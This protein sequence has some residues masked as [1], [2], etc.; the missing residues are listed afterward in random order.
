M[1]RLWKPSVAL[2]GILGLVWMCYQQGI[3]G[4]FL[5]DDFHN[6]ETMGLYG[7]IHDWNTLYTFI[8]TG[9]SG[10]SGRPISLLSFLLDDNTWPS[11]AAWFKVTNVWIHLLCALVLCWNNILILRLIGLKENNTQWMAVFAAGAWALHPF[12]VSTT[13]YVV[14]R[15]AQLSTLF[16]LLGMLGYLFG[17][18]FVS[19]KPRKAYLWM[20]FSVL[21]GTVLAVLSKEN[22]ALLPL[23]L[24]VLEFCLSPKM[25]VPKPHIVWRLIFLITPSLVIIGYLCSLVDFSAHPW[26]GRNFNQP[27]RLMSESRILVGYLRDLVFPSIEGKGLFQD[28]F[29]VSKSLL[30]PQ[31]T[32]PSV[33]LI[34]FLVLFS[35]L[36][37]N[38]YPVLC[39]GLLFFFC[40]HLIESTLVGLELYFEHRNYLP[41]C[42]LFL[43][44]SVGINELTKYGY[45]KISFVIGVA[46]IIFLS[47]MTWKRSELW[48]NTEK[49]QL[50]WAVSS[51]ASARAQNAL[52]SY[53]LR[54]GRYKEANKVLEN[55]MNKMPDS[56]FLN[57]AWLLQKTYLLQA[58]PED[59][60]VTTKRL[61]GQEF[62]AQSIVALRTLVD[63]SNLSKSP[64]FY[65]DETLKLINA[66]EDNHKYAEIPDVSRLL[67][68]LKGKIYLRQ[69]KFL[70]ACDEYKRAISLYNS[71]DSGLMMVAENTSAHNNKCALYLLNV[72][73]ARLGADSSVD[74]S[75]PKDD[76]LKDIKYLR[77]IIEKN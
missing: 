4:G 65:R 55:A 59:F 20:S 44:L 13:L 11:H 41:F 35:L 54:T 71:A 49:L 56:A 7:S 45:K 15:M 53:L 32:L 10:P 57:F 60:E 26:A 16:V 50:Y 66:L 74:L 37:K 22:G 63:N 9:I 21:G 73:D 77:N 40:G 64:G 6:L 31:T 33:F 2:I 52:A 12:L 5:F 70:M 39:F 25:L 51:P 17:R 27:E 24:L 36:K 23:L 68:Y 19:D 61:M 29:L 75:R 30:V 46:L 69:G 42:F 18:K 47:F 1:F 43:A 3:N 28:G 76:Y 8:R 62:N 72:V 48:G 14:Q 58:T 38:K 67:P 34:V